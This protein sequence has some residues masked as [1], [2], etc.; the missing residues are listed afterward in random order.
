MQ[1]ADPN[2]EEDLAAGSPRVPPP[3]ATSSPPGGRGNSQRIH[4]QPDPDES[5]GSTSVVFS[6]LHRHWIDSAGNT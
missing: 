6:K 2:E 3:C 5:V 4:P 1:S